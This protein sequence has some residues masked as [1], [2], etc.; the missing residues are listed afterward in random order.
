M[1]LPNNIICNCI[2]SFYVLGFHIICVC[3]HTGSRCESDI[4]GCESNPCGCLNGTDPANC[5]GGNSVCT[6]VPAANDTEAPGGAYMCGD[7]NSGF[8]RING[9]NS[10][11]IG[12]SFYFSVLI[13]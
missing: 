11:C 4:D 10:N 1:I 6:D 8:E 13:I 2:F 12:K 5:T 3:W 7:C 9:S